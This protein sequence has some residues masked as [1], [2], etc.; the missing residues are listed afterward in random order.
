MPIATFQPDTTASQHAG[1]ING[2]SPTTQ[3]PN[4]AQLFS[5]DDN[6]GS[7]H[8][9]ALLKFN[10]LD[11]GVSIPAGSTINS[12]VL[13]L[14]TE[15]DRSDNT[16]THSIYRMLRSWTEIA[17]WNTY[18]GT[19]N[20]GTAGANNTTTD[21]E[22]TAI[23][24]ASISATESLGVSIDFTLDAA[25][26]QEMIAGGALANNGFLIFPDT[27]LNDMWGFHSPD[28]VTSTNRPKLVIDYTPPV[29]GGNPMF[30]SGGLALG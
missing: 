15:R 6:D 28:A 3:N 22:A 11:D 10:E 21:R 13:T 29:G 12:A 19:N 23:G 26:I 2:D 27:E 5:G 24:G 30:F 16:R 9:R 20:W 17:T 7:G 14:V 1:A 4:L 8:F 18:D 25:K